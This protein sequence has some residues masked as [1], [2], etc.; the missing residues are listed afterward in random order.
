MNEDAKMLLTAP[1]VVCPKCGSKFFKEVYVLKRISPIISPTGEEETMPIPMM[2]CANCGEIPD[3]YKK[4]RN[5]MTIIG[6]ADAK[7][8]KPESSI[9]MP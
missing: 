5:Y 7:E 9:I 6:E 4:K 8:E 2:A 1:N 3:E